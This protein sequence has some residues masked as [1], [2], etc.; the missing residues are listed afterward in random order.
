[1]EMEPWAHRIYSR[2]AE[3]G[4]NQSELAKACGIKEPSV[5][6]WFGKGSRPTR[7]ISGDNLV[8]VAK[9]LG[10][11]PEWIITGKGKKSASDQGSQS[12][13]LDPLMI[14]ETHRALR[15]VYEEE[16]RVYRIE[17]EPAR[18][19]RVYELRASMS[20]T[21]SQEEWVQFGMKLAAVMT[22]QGADIDGRGN[23]APA[24]GAHSKGVARRVQV[25][26]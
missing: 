10:L 7:M 6:G 16:G 8:S 12:V 9:F 5:S 21:P 18:F 23:A 11:T 20:N 13:R 4:R 22:P 15:E 24:Q 17:A 19:M 1:M 3:L 2:M 14:A 26:G 25:K